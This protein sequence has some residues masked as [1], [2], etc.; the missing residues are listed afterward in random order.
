MWSEIG[1]PFLENI[2]FVVCMWETL[3]DFP[4]LLTGFLIEKSMPTN[5]IPRLHE[6][7]PMINDG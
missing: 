3:D 1:K 6:A 2:V 7:T 4:M 5:P